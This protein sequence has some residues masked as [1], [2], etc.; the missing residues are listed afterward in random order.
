MKPSVCQKKYIKKSLDILLDRDPRLSF[1]A[2]GTWDKCDDIMQV[3]L[4]TRIVAKNSRI[5]TDLFHDS[6]LITCCADYIFLQ[7]YMLIIN[8]RHTV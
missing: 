4:R 8:E 6:P 1:L 7:F 3:Q 2:I 5:K